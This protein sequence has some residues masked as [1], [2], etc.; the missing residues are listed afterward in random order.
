M[1]KVVDEYQN[2][3]IDVEN[4][5]KIACKKYGNGKNEQE[6]NLYDIYAEN[7]KNMM[8][9]DRRIE[10]LTK[11]AELLRLDQQAQVK[12]RQGL[13]KV[14]T[15][16]RENPNF[17]A[18]NEAEVDL[19]LESV[20]LLQTLYDASLFKVESAL[21]E[22]LNNTKPNYQYASLMNTTYD[23]SVRLSLKNIRIQ[24][25]YFSRFFFLRSVFS[26]FWNNVSSLIVQNLR[27]YAETLRL[28]S[29][30]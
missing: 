13:E 3:F 17:N 22:L 23:K 2:I 5:I 10:N 27:K 18:N 9:R 30:N 20:Q 25:F 16:A 29:K 24:Y 28:L 7:T 19:K 4:D 1:T 15:F 12:S 14:K 6:I 21:A 8:N 11:W 26:N